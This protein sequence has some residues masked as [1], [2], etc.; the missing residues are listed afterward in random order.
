M[1]AWRGIPRRCKL[2]K[3]RGEKTSSPPLKATAARPPLYTAVGW[4]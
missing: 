3:K 4:G 2:H 1:E